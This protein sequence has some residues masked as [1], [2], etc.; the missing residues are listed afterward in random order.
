[1]HVES[2]NRSTDLPLIP[3]VNDDLYLFGSTGYHTDEGRVVLADLIDDL[4]KSLLVNP[5]VTLGYCL[6]VLLLLVL[7]LH[8]EVLD[9]DA[10]RVVIARSRYVSSS[11]IAVVSARYGNIADHYSVLLLVIFL[12]VSITDYRWCHYLLL[13]LLLL[14][15]P[16]R[17]LLGNYLG[18]LSW[19]LLLLMLV[20]L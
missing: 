15:L 3:P 13:L 14:L 19:L 8:N 2:I 7:L 9:V 10:G 4:T 11:Q 20:L 16:L 18:I 5:C 12:H 6:T 1:M 17:L